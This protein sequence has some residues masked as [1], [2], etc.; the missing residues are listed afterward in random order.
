[1]AV[2]FHNDGVP[3]IRISGAKTSVVTLEGCNYLDPAKVRR[4]WNHFLIEEGDLVI[5]GSASSG[6]VAEVGK[7]A[8]GS[9]LYTGLMRL[10]IRDMDL[11][12]KR[13]FE[14]F[15]ASP[16]FDTQVELLKAGSTIAHYGPSHLGKMFI[17]VPPIEEQRA[18]VA[19]IDEASQ[20]IEDG[21]AIKERQIAA[22][23]EFK[24]SLINA[25][26]TGK[27]KVI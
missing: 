17:I 4:K 16:S 13:F 10:R 8:A 15:L 25:A 21:I 9:V 7:E 2:D 20:K 23:K 19:H 3:L 14:H 11:L 22:L 12:L 5:S 26:V 1:M 6:L 24:T 18:I 27:I